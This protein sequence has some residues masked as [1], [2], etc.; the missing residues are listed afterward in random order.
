MGRSAYRLSGRGDR[1][2]LQ[3]RGNPSF[4]GSAERIVVASLAAQVAAVDR[5]AE[6]RRLPERERLVPAEVAHRPAR[7]FLVE[8]GE[9]IAARKALEAR[10]GRQGERAA[11]I[12]TPARAL[13]NRVHFMAV[14]RVGDERGY[15][16]IGLSQI[17]ECSGD[18][19][20]FADHDREEILYAEIDPERAR[21][22]KI[23]NIPG[24]Y[25]VDRVHD[26]RPDLYGGLTD[27]GS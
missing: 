23:V 17:V 3:Q 14:N 24:E 26:R 18:K 7:A 21:Q 15:H 8:P 12:L 9:L 16:F 27:S 2:S 10:D 1:R 25:E 19:L 5:L 11:R 13:E 20:A 6:H 22:K 4:E